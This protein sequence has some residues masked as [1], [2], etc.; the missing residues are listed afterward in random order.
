MSFM[1]EDD[2]VLLKYNEIWSKIKNTFNTKLNSMS[3]YNKKG[4]KTKVKD[5]TFKFIVHVS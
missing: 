5:N 4:I 2:S 3:V 1:I